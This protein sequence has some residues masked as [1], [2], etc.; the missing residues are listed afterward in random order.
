MLFRLIRAIADEL[1]LQHYA[2]IKTRPGFAQ[3]LQDLFAE[4]KAEQALPEKLRDAMR[5]LGDEPRLREL[6]ALYDAYQ[7]RLRENDWAD[8]A[9]LGW[10]AVGALNTRAPQVARDW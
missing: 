10:L 8:R 2:A 7:T 1:D 9:G 6:V 4:L 3:A 5:A